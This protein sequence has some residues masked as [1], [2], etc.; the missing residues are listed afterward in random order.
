VKM[1]GT[2]AGPGCFSRGGAQLGGR[3]RHCLVIGR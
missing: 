1:H 2:G 3:H